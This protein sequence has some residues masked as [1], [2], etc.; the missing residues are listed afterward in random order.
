MKIFLAN[1]SL[2]RPILKYTDTAVIYNLSISPL[3]KII[4]GPKFIYG[5]K[6]KN[7]KVVV[8]VLT[9]L[10]FL[11]L[12][13]N[14]ASY[15]NIY[16]SNGDSTDLFFRKTNFNEEKNAPSIFSSLLHLFASFL[17]G[18]T[19]RSH[20]QIKIS[21]KFWFTLSFI[22]L[23][24]G[25]DELLRIHE[26][27]EGNSLEGFSGMFLYNWIIYYGIALIILGFILFKSLLKLP[28]KTLKG[29][30]FAGIIFLSGAIG[31]E[32]FTGGYIHLHKLSENLI[33]NTPLVF[34]LYT[35]EELLE[36]IGV[37][38]FIYHLLLFLGQYKNSE[39]E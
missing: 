39:R 38:I 2:N 3:I 8:K 4:F 19:G 37:S 35:I 31:V 18:L 1:V 6:W 14:V 9:A 34:T 24:L 26:K 30:F 17:L 27:L 32:N 28:K 12:L 7:P 21:K 33:I 10:I 29:F 15:L 22:F 5:M 36:M 20:L 13:L 11:L 16:L 23:F 25:M